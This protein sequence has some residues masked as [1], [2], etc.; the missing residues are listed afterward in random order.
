MKYGHYSDNEICN[1]KNFIEF[2]ESNGYITNSHGYRCPEWDQFSNNKKNIVVL[3]CSHTFG[4]VLNEGEVWVDQL[5]AKTDQTVLQWWNLGQSGAS[6]DLIVRILYATEKLLFPNI[7]IIC[8]PAWNR[9]ERLLNFDKFPLHQNSLT[10]GDILLKYENEDTDQQNFLKNVFF[11]EKFAENTNATIL[12]CF[13]QEI[14]EISNA[15]VYNDSCIKT[16]L[17]DPILAKDN[18]HYDVQHHEIFAEGV[19]NRFKSVW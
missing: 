15:E 12:H 10:S 1:H 17:S 3:G 18:M 4:V 11:A 9:R 14:Y 2:N 5:A 7:I 6:A 13:A 8:W 19:F 16:C